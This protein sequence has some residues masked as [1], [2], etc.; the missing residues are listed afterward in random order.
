MMEFVC[1]DFSPF[2]LSEQV[3]SLTAF[4]NFMDKSDGFECFEDNLPVQIA[5]DISARLAYL[6]SKGVAHRDLKAKNVLVSNQPHD[7]R[8]EQDESVFRVLHIHIY[9]YI[10]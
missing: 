5:H 9:I 4:L 2:D 1:F 7:K 6:H 10:I 3:T 8:R